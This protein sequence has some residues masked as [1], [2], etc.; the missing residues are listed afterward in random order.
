[1]KQLVTTMVALF[2]AAF[3]FAQNNAQSATL[4]YNGAT[5]PGTSINY[6]LPPDETEK[7]IRDQM[8]SLGLVP[9]K[10]KGYLVYRNVNIQRVDSDGPVDMI[11]K[12]D[13]AGSKKDPASVV[14]LITAKPGEIPTEKVKGA[15]K[16]LATITAASTA[17]SFLESFQGQVN[18][19]AHSLAV[20]AKEKE[21]ADAEKE[22]D[23]MKKDNDKMQSKLEKLQKDIDDNQKAQESQNSKIQSLKAELQAL[24]AVK[25]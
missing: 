2:F 11:F 20:Q 21:V 24:K 16:E 25:S 5:Y 19:Q 6:N 8:S 7:V 23:K 12:I 4:K 17:G 22:F 18:N 1:M 9:E 3:G 10:G 15:G 13:K 14:T